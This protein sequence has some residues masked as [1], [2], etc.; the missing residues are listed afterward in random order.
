[1]LAGESFRSHLFGI[2]DNKCIDRRG[3]G[4]KETV[5]EQLQACKT[6]VQLCRHLQENYSCVVDIAI[7][8]VET[9]FTNNLLEVYSTENV[10]HVS[11][12]KDVRK[13]GLT[14]S[15]LT[16]PGQIDTTI[17]NHIF[18]LRIDLILKDYF[19]KRIRLDENIYTGF[20]VGSRVD[21]PDFD[22]KFLLIPQKFLENIVSIKGSVFVH[23]I[24]NQIKKVI[25]VKYLKTLINTLHP[26]ATHMSW[27]PLYTIANRLHS[28]IWN[29]VHAKYV[30]DQKKFEIVLHT[31]N[32]PSHKINDIDAYNILCKDL[33]GE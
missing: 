4:K 5:A 26:G 30:F 3:K 25:D 18:F 23:R 8:T 14:E 27:N 12:I 9:E 6:H 33:N 10:V 16:Y 1:M 19:F 32:I 21:T 22:D 13:G 15:F 2:T 7:E 24:F 20:S 28:L 31:F 17:Y 11:L 29:R